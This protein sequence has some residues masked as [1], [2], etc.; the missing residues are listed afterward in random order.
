MIRL[1]GGY[2]N[3]EGHGNTMESLRKII[4]TIYDKYILR[5]IMAIAKVINSFVVN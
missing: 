1:Q 3:M 5:D 2:K 4:D